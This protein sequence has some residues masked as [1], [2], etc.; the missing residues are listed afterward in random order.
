MI[1]DIFGIIP[2]LRNTGIHLRVDEEQWKIVQGSK[3]Q[4]SGYD[5][6]APNLSGLRLPD[7]PHAQ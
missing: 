6:H 1:V 2:T 3:R 7:T 5:P 4:A